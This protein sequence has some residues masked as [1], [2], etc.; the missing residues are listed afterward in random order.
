[1]SR[2]RRRV[3]ASDAARFTA[4]VVLPTPPFWFAMAMTRFMPTVYCTAGPLPRRTAATA[5]RL[6][7][8]GHQLLRAACQALARYADDAAGIDDVIGRV[9]DA[10]RLQRDAVLALR[11]LIIG[12]ARDDA[13][14]QPR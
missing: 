5:V 12:S 2:T 4:V 8:S 9:E 11:Q 7:D 6:Q 13:R 1:M 10:R 14:A 3:A